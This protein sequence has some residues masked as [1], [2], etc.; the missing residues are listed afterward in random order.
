MS[1]LRNPVE[2]YPN[3]ENTYRSIKLPEKW[4]NS[5][6]KLKFCELPENL[7]WCISWLY[8]IKN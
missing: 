2:I 1:K 8:S 3:Y 5:C 7:G 4:R 6:F